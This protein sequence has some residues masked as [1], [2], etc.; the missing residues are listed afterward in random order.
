MFC[1]SRFKGYNNSFQDRWQKRIYQTS[2]ES[3]TS[4]R[5]DIMNLFIE[6]FYFKDDQRN[7]EVFESIEKN[8]SLSCI[9]RIYVIAPK[10]TLEYL[11]NHQVG[12]NNKGLQ[13]ITHSP[14]CLIK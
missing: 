7:I 11:I 9:D 5:K 13:A 8:C 14:L 10:E 4:R 12:K 3:Q 2:N 1:K 6:Y